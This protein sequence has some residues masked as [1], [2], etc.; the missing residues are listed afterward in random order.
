MNHDTQLFKIKAGSHYVAQGGLKLLGSTD[1][2]VSASQI[3]RTTG[4]YHHVL[5]LIFMM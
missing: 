5:S 3:A 2:S 4:I 1:L